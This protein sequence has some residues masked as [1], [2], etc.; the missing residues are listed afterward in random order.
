MEPAATATALTDAASHLSVLDL[1]GEASLI[2]KTIMLLLLGL[3][4][5]TWAILF[6]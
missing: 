3:S 5:V 2:V 6:K 1:F 4:F